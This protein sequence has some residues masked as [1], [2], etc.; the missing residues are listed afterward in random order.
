MIN[1]EALKEIEEKVPLEGSYEEDARYHW[2]KRWDM[3]RTALA[4]RPKV[5]MHE[6]SELLGRIYGIKVMDALLSACLW[7][8]EKGVEVEEE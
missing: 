2:P 5:T 1:E 4:P 6:V 8:R 7:L 3:V